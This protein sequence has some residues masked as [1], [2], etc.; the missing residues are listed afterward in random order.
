MHYGIVQTADSASGA[1]TGQVRGV[2]ADFGA[3]AADLRH[4]PFVRANPPMAETDIVNGVRGAVVVI[5]RGAVPLVE[6]ARRAQAAGAAAAVIV[7]TD[8][9][10]LLAHGHRHRDGTHDLGEDITIPVLVVAQSAGSLFGDGSAGVSVD[11][12]YSIGGAQSDA[13]RDRMPAEASARAPELAPGLAAAGAAG[14]AESA[15]YAV[16]SP[17]QQHAPAP[18]Q[19]YTVSAQQQQQ[20]QQQQYAAPAQ[21]QQQQYTVPTSPQQLAVSPPQPYAAPL[22]QNYSDYVAP[23]LQQHAMLRV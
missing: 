19:Q 3:R 9:R 23:P 8:E 6:K 11:V 13:G 20:Q 2:I 22:Q 1:A 16:P 15:R 10:P 7:N 4:L 17:P 12:S 5:D 21:Q 14:A 18:Q